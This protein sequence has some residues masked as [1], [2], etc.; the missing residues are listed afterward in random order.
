MSKQFKLTDTRI[1]NTKPSDKPQKLTDGGGLFMLVTPTGSKLW[2]YRYR[3]GGKENVFALG[4]YGQPPAGERESAKGLR[5][6]AGVLSLSEAR[7]ALATAKQ[8]VK[9]GIHP[10]A[11]RVESRKSAARARAT[12]FEGV[13]REW[14]ARIGS[15]WK[16][17]TFRQRERLLECDVFPEIGKRPIK[18]IKRIELNEVIL[19]I[20]KRAPQMAVLARQLIQSVFD[21]AEATGSIEESIALRL[22]SVEKAKVIHARQLSVENVGEFLV[23]CEAY[24]GQFETREAMR[25]AWL[26]L[27]RTMEVVGAQWEEIDLDQ[28]IWRIP[29]ERMKMQRDHII[30]LSNQT[31]ALLEGLK[32]VTGKTPFLFPNRNDRKRP[33]SC[34][35]LWKMVDSI[36]WRGRFTPH[37]LRGTASTIMNE[38]GLW[39][40]DVIERLL[41]HTE[42]NKVRASYNAAEYI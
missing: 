28:G 33:S 3:I 26:T 37:G 29:A 17:P 19:K 20:E 11:D 15:K 39:S 31:K 25:L 8:L 13:S 41:A 21:H 2:R 4:E 34:G 6:S 1:R 35:L 40:P 38:S 14:L 7:E 32:A 23:S 12:T 5:I 16:S 18:A 27:A 42:Q 9:N 24:P 36:G 30:P 22:V 10:S